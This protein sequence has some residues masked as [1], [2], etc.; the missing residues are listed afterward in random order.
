MYFN[1]NH[2]PLAL[3]S[4]LV[5]L[6]NCHSIIEQISEI[7]TVYNK[8]FRPTTPNTQNTVELIIAASSDL[9]STNNLQSANTYLYCLGSTKLEIETVGNDE[10][11]GL[12]IAVADSLVEVRDK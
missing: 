3:L 8:S 4:F 1:M 7:T 11:N 2:L 12:K 9:S 5:P 6:A 10:S